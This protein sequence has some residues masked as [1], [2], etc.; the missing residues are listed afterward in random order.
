MQIS[1]TDSVVGQAIDQQLGLVS[2][3]VIRN[4][5]V[6]GGLKGMLK[7]LITGSQ[8]HYAQACV[9]SRQEAIN[10]M[11]EEAE[12]LGANGIVGVHFQTSIYYEHLTEVMAYGT[13]VVL[14]A[15]SK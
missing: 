10:I 12:L 7:I 5:A 9:A 1:T 8:K 14:R 13:A 15:N 6:K 11:I 4:P 3:V 2:G